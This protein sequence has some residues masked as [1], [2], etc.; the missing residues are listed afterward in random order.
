MTVMNKNEQRLLRRRDI[1]IL[2]LIHQNGDTEI[3]AADISEVY[4]KSVRS[5]DSL[6]QDDGILLRKEPLGKTLF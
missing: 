1:I 4:R 5:R 6:Y 3:I 2:L